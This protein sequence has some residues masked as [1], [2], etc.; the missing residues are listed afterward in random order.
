M[1][2]K[3]VSETPFLFGFAPSSA[4]PETPSGEF[5]LVLAE[6]SESGT[7]LSTKA[8]VAGQEPIAPLQ[9]LDSPELRQGII[10]LD[11]GPQ[12]RADASF[13]T[14]GLP[15]V[16]L[17]EQFADSMQ[18][19]SA[20]LLQ[21][22]PESLSPEEPII[23]GNANGQPTSEDPVYPGFLS[24]IQSSS[25]RAEGGIFLEGQLALING[26]SETDPEAD[27]LQNSTLES[28]E[29]AI[30]EKHDAVISDAHETTNAPFDLAAL[31]HAEQLR[32]APV[33]ADVALAKGAELA[34]EEAERD[35]FK[36][37][38]KSFDQL[39]T[40]KSV[41]EI[42]FA[43]ASQIERLAL[44]NES[45]LPQ[46]S[47][48][49]GSESIQP[50]VTL[51][52]VMKSDAPRLPQGTPIYPISLAGNEQAVWK[53]FSSV[54]EGQVGGSFDNP[55]SLGKGESTIGE[56]SAALRI[57]GITVTEESSLEPL[58]LKDSV[59]A[60]N[61]TPGQSSSAAKGSSTDPSP[62]ASLIG[63][64]KQVDS[65]RQA[66]A[67]T[68]TALQK[69][70]GV[71]KTEVA[72][73]PKLDSISKAVV[74]PHVVTG[75]VPGIDHGQTASVPSVHSSAD[76]IAQAGSG[77]ASPQP[78]SE[79]GSNLNVTAPFFSETASSQVSAS[80]LAWKEL[81]DSK[82]VE[83]PSTKRNDGRLS[84]EGNHSL[85]EIRS[86]TVRK[87][88][89]HIDR[90]LVTRSK[91][92]SVIR[93]QPEELGSITMVVRNIKNDIEAVV[94]ASDERVR[95]LLQDSRQDLIHS[96]QQRGHADIRVSVA[97]EANSADRQ[98]SQRE[99]S[100]NQDLNQRNNGGSEFGN[101]PG[102]QHAQRD[103]DRQ[104]S[105]SHRSLRFENER[106]MKGEDSPLKK[107]ETFRRFQKVIDVA[108]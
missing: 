103:Q 107:T 60:K 1:E 69:E 106:L 31:V 6:V 57:V 56:I 74:D 34:L 105:Q 12:G 36:A 17:P 20:G 87:V 70:A 92:E 38:G 18:G 3:N 10:A 80:Q 64:G 27:L 39:A 63:P 102:G 48:L 49:V 77:T 59:P 43:K 66:V 79:D 93:M 88:A 50:E 62:T 44:T 24:L 97:S 9:I 40:T 45:G 26:G 86:E 95:E 46:S 33:S 67:H 11:L 52:L 15:V 21:T 5:A 54:F 19:I 96:L 35:S 55:A 37:P 51:G 16:D 30:A 22:V 13:V 101:S 94:T 73:R 78:W 89:E 7:P 23:I 71:A 29:T 91:A 82:G 81:A 58:V 41:R 104:G 14:P 68:W 108:I 100:S 25:A 90:L 53:D 85:L 98:S 61:Q 84:I 83:A 65:V 42:L 32:N 72:S 8:E 4:E 99:S 28:G 47:P 76:S 2:V 75:S